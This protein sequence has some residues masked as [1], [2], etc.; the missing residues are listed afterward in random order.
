MKAKVLISLIIVAINICCFNIAISQ[1]LQMITPSKVWHVETGMSCTEGD[2]YGCFCYLGTTTI[3]VGNIRTFDGNNYYEIISSRD[4]LDEEVTT[5]VREDGNK[6]FFYACEHEYLM[7]DFDVNVGDEIFLAN[8]LLLHWAENG[9]NCHELT[10][11]EYSKFTITAIDTIE[12][13]NISRK[14]IQLLPPQGVI[15]E[16]WIEGIGCIRGLYFNV[17][18]NMSGAKMV[19]DCYESGELVFEN[20]NPEFTWCVTGVG[21]DT[22][23]DKIDAHI[24]SY[25]I[26]HIVN[27]KDSYISI[28]N[29]QGQL[30]QTVVPD[31]DDF[32][33]NVSSLPA[34]LYVIKSNDK[35]ESIKV[36]NP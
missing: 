20:E 28:Y 15:P 36:F 10:D 30:L 32:N 25:N 11:S 12:Y 33:I 2:G 26:L 16:Y 31:N 35:N 18:Y 7:Y 4:G 27:A 24:D 17:V 3:S 21:N 14:R 13:A 22:E 29:L 19:K 6:V 34:G 8:P 23:I 9:N 1:N 5:Y